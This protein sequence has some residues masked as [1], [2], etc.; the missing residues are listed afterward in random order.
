MQGVCTSDFEGKRAI[1][2]YPLIAVLLGLIA[3]AIT[4]SLLIFLP[5]FAPKDNPMAGFAMSFLGLMCSFAF[6]GG[7]MFLF[8]TVAK[9]QFVWFGISAVVAYLVG[10]SVYAVQNIRKLS[11]PSK[12]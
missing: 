5:K 1:F 12:K 10:L 8:N 3:G 4:L 6:G 2:S 11:V 9:N 7:V